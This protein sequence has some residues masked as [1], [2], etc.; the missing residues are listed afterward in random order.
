M[1]QTLECEVYSGFA[2]TL[3]QRGITETT[4]IRPV[5]DSVNLHLKEH[6]HIK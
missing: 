5:S 6:K 2:S 1:F 4:P 3:L